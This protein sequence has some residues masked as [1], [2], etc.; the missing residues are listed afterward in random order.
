VIE[1]PEFQSRLGEPPALR[2]NTE[3]SIPESIANKRAESYGAPQASGGG[4]FLPLI[5][6]VGLKAVGDY[7]TSKSQMRSQERISRYD[8]RMQM[9]LEDKRIAAARELDRERR[10]LPD[11]AYSA[12]K[13]ELSRPL[14]PHG[15]VPAK[16]GSFKEIVSQAR[17]AVPQTP[18]LGINWRA[19]IEPPRLKA[20]PM[21][22]AV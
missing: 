17:S 5:V 9:E 1:V 10:R 4:W 14:A 6:E 15:N 16:I 18:S 3:P 21:G 19:T 7:F 8:W 22:G 13:E 20:T 12:L 2:Y 11:W